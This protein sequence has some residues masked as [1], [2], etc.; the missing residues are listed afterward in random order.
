MAEKSIRDKTVRGTFWSAA[1]A[2]L[3]HGVT[4][5]VGIVLARILSPAEYGL[6]GICTI[7]TTVLTGIVI[8]GSQTLLSVRM[9]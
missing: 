4:F 9:M 3:G 8:V 7:F 1:D 6:I 5:I 2:L